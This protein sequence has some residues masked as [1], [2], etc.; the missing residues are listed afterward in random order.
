MS[1]PWISLFKKIHDKYDASKPFDGNTVYGMSA[2]YL[3]VQAL[4][5]AG[6]NPTRQSL[7]DALNTKGS[8]YR[9]PGLV[10]LGFSKNYHGGYLGAQI[11]KINNGSIT[12][13][14]PVYVTR[15]TGPIT[16]YSKPQPA[17]PPKL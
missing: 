11:G 2:G 17:P 10:P 7:V 8:S 14:G 13:T 15:D 16:T 9:G 5:S 3:F 12:P 4:R 6:K 1:N